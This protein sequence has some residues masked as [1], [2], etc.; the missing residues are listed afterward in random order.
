MKHRVRAAGILVRGD[1][2]LLVL[3]RHPENGSEWWIPPGGGLKEEDGSI[4]QT[5]QREIF[6]ETGL[7]VQLSRISYIREFRETSTNIHHLEFFLPVDAYSGEITLE[8][9]PEGDL[10]DGIIKAVKW[11]PRSEL[12]DRVVWP[13]WIKEDWFWQDA[14]AGFPEIIYT[15]VGKD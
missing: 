9:I 5:A 8:N 10:D 12:G 2:I 15:G 4:F 11:L 6:E 14:K 7:T 3:H 13:E 1:S